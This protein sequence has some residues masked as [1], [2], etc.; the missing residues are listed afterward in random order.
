MIMK[1]QTVRTLMPILTASNLPKA[2]AARRPVVVSHIHDSSIKSVGLDGRLETE[3]ELPFKPN[4]FDFLAECCLVMAGMDACCSRSPTS[5][6]SP[7]S[8][9]RRA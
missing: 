3:L 6:I 1:D 2:R 7:A 5:A 4:G 8:A 9:R